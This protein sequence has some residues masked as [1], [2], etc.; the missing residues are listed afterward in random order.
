MTKE[1]IING[2]EAFLLDLDGTVYLSEIPI[3]NMIDTLRR[4]RRM[5]KRI[6]YL[7]N[8]SLQTE[9]EYRERLKKICLWEEGDRVYTSATAARFCLLEKYAGERVYMFA[10]D[11]LKEQFRLAGVNVV[12]EDPSVCLLAYDTTATF[13]K[14]CK[15]NEFLQRGAVY[16]AT[17]LDLVC[18]TKTLP[19]PDAGAFA[20]LFRASSERDPD[21]VCGKPG[22]EMARLVSRD[23][24]L[25]CDKMCMVGD[26]LYTDI[27]FG[28]VNGMKTVL[29]L[30][31]E[32]T[33]ENMK[34][35]PDVPD[36]VLPTLNEL[37]DFS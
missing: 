5:G 13:D 33:R 32:A 7:T 31:G 26:R 3:G 6:V 29:V 22:R 17:H 34:D 30:S 4:L 19:R 37:L 12:E 10:N 35:Y 25:P 2:S 8:A 24:R 9:G 36:L 1:E 28:L 16:I 20:A 14:I 11:S 18:P 27:R 21:L 23:L 15:F